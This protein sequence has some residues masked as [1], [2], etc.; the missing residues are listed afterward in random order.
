MENREINKK[1]GRPRSVD[2]KVNV[3]IY[4]RESVVESYGGM[5]EYRKKLKELSEE[6]LEQLNIKGV[7]NGTTESYG[8]C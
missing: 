1:M 5:E 7:E 2:K 4:V 8:T 6:Y 3:Q